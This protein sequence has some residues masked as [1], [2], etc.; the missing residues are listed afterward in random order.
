MAKGLE[1]NISDSNEINELEA[2]GS[3]GRGYADLSSESTASLGLKESITT[4]SSSMEKIL[5]QDEGATDGA[6]HL[7]FLTAKIYNNR[8]AIGKIWSA[9]QTIYGSKQFKNAITGSLKGNAETAT[10]A[11]SINPT[12]GSNLTFT[13]NKTELQITDGTRTWKIAASK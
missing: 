1:L 3:I 6:N 7:K 5:N 12:A 13:V 8:E 11:S 2:S 10:S 4:Y 9:D